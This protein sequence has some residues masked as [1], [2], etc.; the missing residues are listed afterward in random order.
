MK[1][2]GCDI[3]SCIVANVIFSRHYFQSIDFL[4][5]M[6]CS[7]CQCLHKASFILCFSPMFSA[8][9]RTSRWETPTLTT[10]F[11]K[12]LKPETWIL[13]RYFYVW[14]DLLES[15]CSVNVNKVEQL[16]RINLTSFRQNTVES[17][18]G[19]KGLNEREVIPLQTINI[20][21]TSVLMT[22]ITG[23]NLPWGSRNLSFFNC[24]IKVWKSCGILL[25]KNACDTCAATKYI[26][27]TR[28]MSGLVLQTW[29]ARWLRRKYSNIWVY[30]PYLICNEGPSFMK[31]T[32]IMK[33]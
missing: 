29:W 3:L 18:V 8:L 2:S 6:I 15:S 17:G 33:L 24:L 21:I 31:T 7:F 9:Q 27:S 12:L 16:I 28:N 20:D 11:W 4:F 32:D 26:L 19:M 22:P 5:M 30:Y 10:D 25:W 1:Q 23:N 14:T 13:S